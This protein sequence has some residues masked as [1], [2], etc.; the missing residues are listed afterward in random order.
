MGDPPRRIALAGPF[1]FVLI[2]I[3]LAA[4]GT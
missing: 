1:F 3:E 2:G 4:A